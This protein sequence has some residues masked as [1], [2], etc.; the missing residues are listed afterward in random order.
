VL[1]A[2]LGYLGKNSQLICVHLDNGTQPHRPEQPNKT[3]LIELARGKKSK[4]QSHS[5][6]NAIQIR[7]DPIPMCTAKSRKLKQLEQF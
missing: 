6:A 4:D 7:F 1:K 3:H 2:R 5:L